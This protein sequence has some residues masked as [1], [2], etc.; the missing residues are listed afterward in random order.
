[1]VEGMPNCSECAFQTWCGSDPVRH[2]TIHGDFVGHKPT[3]EFCYRNMETMR[4]LVRL[5]EDD[6]EAARILRRWIR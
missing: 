3:S 1:M 2:H 6:P 5:M 4:Y